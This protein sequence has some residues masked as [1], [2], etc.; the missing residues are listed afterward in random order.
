M[1]HRADEIMTPTNPSL[2]RSCFLFASLPGPLQTVC[3]VMKGE[4]S[5]DLKILLFS[6]ISI[7]W[8][9]DLASN[10]IKGREE[11]NLVGGCDG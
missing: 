1:L 10:T 4:G 5:V 3:L 6:N 11:E 9:L 7:N 2:T 8:F